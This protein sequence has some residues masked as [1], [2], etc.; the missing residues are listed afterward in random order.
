MLFRSKQDVD[1][2]LIKPSLCNNTTYGHD[3]AADKM[4]DV[5]VTIP[6]RGGLQLRNVVVA[7]VV[8]EVGIIVLGSIKEVVFVN[9]ELI[10]LVWYVLCTSTTAHSRPHAKKILY[11]SCCGVSRKDGSIKLRI[12]T[13]CTS[14]DCWKDNILTMLSVGVVDIVVAAVVV[15]F[16]IDDDDDAS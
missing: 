8:V 6:F 7:V 1:R 12:I 4:G 9:D 5:T 14:E 13:G 16:I 10:S 15:W 3:V 2:I 11:Q